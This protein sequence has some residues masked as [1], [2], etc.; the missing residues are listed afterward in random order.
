[1][2]SAL[3]LALTCW[4]A[5]AQSAS[6]DYR[7]YVRGVETLSLSYA[8]SVENAHYDID[9]SLKAVGLASLAIKVDS[10][11]QSSGSINGMTLTPT[12][13]QFDDYVQATRKSIVGDQVVAV[14]RN[15]QRRDYQR[16]PEAQGAVDMMA[17]IGQMLWQ[18]SLN[19]TC[20]GQRIFYD[21]LDMAR[22]NMHTIGPDVIKQSRRQRAGGTTLKCRI[23]AESLTNR[24]LGISQVDVWM[25]SLS[26]DGL[27]LPI[28]MTWWIKGQQA[29]FHLRSV[30]P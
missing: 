3:T 9:A 15:G 26:N 8:V 11:Y 25:A 17:G 1:M 16:P 14:G 13:F 24:P 4:A 2:L 30:S 6:L 10:R 18:A 21:G 27:L 22:L 7:G 19:G 20:D 5:N 28:Q 23:T 12:S 29:M